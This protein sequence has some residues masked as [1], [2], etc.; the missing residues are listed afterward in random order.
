MNPAEV[1]VGNP[2]LND[3]IGQSSGTSINPD[4]DEVLKLIKKSEYKVVDQLMPTLSKISM[5][6]VLLNSDAHRE[7]LMRVLDQAFVD[8]DVTTDQFGGIV[9]N[10]TACNNLS[11]SDE[12]LPEEGRNHNFALHISMNCQT[13]SLSNVLVDTGSSLNVMPKTTL[14]RLS[15]QGMPMKSSGVVVKAFDG[16]RKSVIGEV[17]LPMTI[18][19]HTFQV[20]FQVMDVQAAYSCLLG[21]PW[22]HEAGAV[23]S[24]LHQKLKFITNGK[25]VT[26]SGEQAL[27]VIHLSSFSYISADDVEGTQF[28]GLS[29][30]NKSTKKDRAFISSY[31]DAVQIVKDG[32]TTGWGQVV[33]PVNNETRTGL[34]FSPV[35]SKFPKKDETLRTLKEVFHNGG[36]LNPVLQEVNVLIEENTEGELSDSE[37][38]WKSYLNDSG[39]ISQEELYTP[40]CPPSEKSK[41]M[42]QPNSKKVI[43]PIPAEVWDTLGQPSGKFDFMVKYAA[44]ESSKISIE[45]I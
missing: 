25:L 4:F 30:E 38:E 3:G 10:I 28:Q 6:Y 40:F 31:K 13:D 26:I 44:P 17:N 9:A 27:L 35:L 43:P 24:T 34:G 22:I 23:T 41:G 7:A 29:L 21:R 18:G 2:N 37:E 12:E 33:T 20:T 11:F 14:A 15:Y 36:F 5:L 42:F 1:P 39:Y 32:T 8:H 16:S 45:D 19:P